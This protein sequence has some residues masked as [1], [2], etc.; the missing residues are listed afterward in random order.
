MKYETGRSM[1]EMLA[2]LSIIGVLSVG[3]VAGFKTAMNKHKANELIQELKMHSVS[4]AGQA[5]SQ[6]LPENMT[7]NNTKYQFVYKKET[8]KSYSLS[9]N[10]VD[11]NICRI[12]QNNTAFQ[13]AETVLIN[14]GKGCEN[15]NNSLVFFMN[16]SL[17]SDTTNENRIMTCQKD[18]DCGECGQCG[19]Q[20][21]CLF[22]DSDCI[23]P[24]KP[25]CNKG[26][27]QSCEVGYMKI[28]DG[29]CRFCPY[30]N[31]SYNI[32]R[33]E[34]YACPNLFME[35]TEDTGRCI[36]CP[37]EVNADKTD[38]LFDCPV[39]QMGNKYLRACVSCSDADARLDGYSKTEC[40]K[41]SGIRFWWS[42]YSACRFCDDSTNFH[43]TYRSDCLTCSQRYMG[44]TDE[45]GNCRLCTGFVNL[46][47][48][49]CHSCDSTANIETT[50]VRCQQCQGQRY[51]DNGL[52]I[53]C[54]QDI[55][56]LS[57]AQQSW[58]L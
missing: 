10:D 38:C 28:A 29:T 58:C 55:S 57:D 48:T 50:E 35:G 24:E 42:Q 8:D 12:V 51:Y 41:C 44:G 43:Y 25:Y 4:L 39:G 27:C 3:A 16:T 5:L 15:E 2:T 19:P 21:V 45:E 23:D 18:S 40:D 33:S 53:L 22:S 54:P 47:G 36:R 14:D 34:C 6:N 56:N 46:D 9:L 1:V 13:W 26:K 31:D 20:N 32:L 30:F 49:A 37:G 52:C 17:T 7:L 11:E